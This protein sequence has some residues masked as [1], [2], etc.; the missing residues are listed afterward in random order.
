ML[1]FPIPPL[2][3]LIVLTMTQVLN[4]TQETPSS[5][6]CSVNAFKGSLGVVDSAAFPCRGSPPGPIITQS[7][8]K[9]LM[10]VGMLIP[11]S[12]RSMLSSRRPMPVYFVFPEPSI[13]CGYSRSL[14]HHSYMAKCL[15]I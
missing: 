4:G 10:S 8:S 2:K 14:V 15:S 1:G 13:V 3:P 12:E 7:E 11:R 9:L 5:T 6:V